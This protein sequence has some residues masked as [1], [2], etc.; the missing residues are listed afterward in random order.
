[1]GT[2]PQPAP[3]PFGGHRSFVARLM[4][5][6]AQSL[7]GDVF[8]PSARLAE[9][10]REKP[11]SRVILLGFIR[12]TFFGQI[13]SVEALTTAYGITWLVGLAFAVGAYVWAERMVGPAI[14]L[15]NAIPEAEAIGPDG[16]PSP[17]LEQTIAVVKRNSVLE[18]GFFVVIFI[19]MILMRIG[20]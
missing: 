11:Q 8:T 14:E 20:L 3:P 18:L 16:R 5:R 17:A 6:S 15:M 7:N 9:V 12:G 2:C 4:R 1:M 19:C 13:K 10:R